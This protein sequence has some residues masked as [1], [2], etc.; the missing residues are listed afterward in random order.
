VK[1]SFN[2]SGKIKDD[3]FGLFIKFKLKAFTL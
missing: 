3:I 1:F 2:V